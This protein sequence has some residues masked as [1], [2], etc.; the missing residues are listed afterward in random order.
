MGSSR[1]CVAV[2]WL[3]PCKLAIR[4]VTASVICTSMKKIEASA[5]DMVLIASLQVHVG[6]AHGHRLFAIVN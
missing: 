1:A 5:E 3:S 2:P 4:E 6:H